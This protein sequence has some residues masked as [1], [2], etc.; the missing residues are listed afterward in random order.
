MARR[1]DHTREELTQ[2]AIQIGHEMMALKGYREFSIR[3]VAKNMGYTVGTLYNLFGSYNQFVLRIN[4]V[5]LDKMFEAVSKDKEEQKNMSIKRLAKG[6]IEFAH[7]N[8][9]AWTALFEFNLSQGEALPDYYQAKIHKLFTL[10]EESLSE[11]TMDEAHAKSMAKVVWASIH[12][13]CQLGLTGKLETVGAESIGQMTDMLI[14]QV[15][16]GLKLLN[17]QES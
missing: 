14:N 2:L 7:K 9:H 17:R 5:T 10:V 1:S 15:L 11:H 3:Q 16:V 8:F 6:Y 13:I 4:A 12:G